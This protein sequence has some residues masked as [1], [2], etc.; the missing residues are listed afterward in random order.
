MHSA[1]LQSDPIRCSRG[2]RVMPFQLPAPH[3]PSLS[4][5]VPWLLGCC[6]AAAWPSAT[7]LMAA[8]RMKGARRYAMLGRRACAKHHHANLDVSVCAV[9]ATSWRRPGDLAWGQLEAGVLEPGDAICGVA[10]PRFEV[11]LAEN[12]GS[13]AVM[14]SRLVSSRAC[15]S[16]LHLCISACGHGG[17]LLLTFW[18]AGHEYIH[19]VSINPSCPQ[20]AA[21]KSSSQSSAFLR[22]QN[23][24]SDAPSTYAC[25]SYQLSLPSALL[26]SRPS[27]WLLS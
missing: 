1:E 22:I 17:E 3:L 8:E 19:V 16:S 9:P 2:D 5:S 23:S 27:R 14:S 12:W 18:A 15:P 24:V 6:L 10:I 21:I 13:V 26:G 7:R 11:C 4:R 25:A 20:P